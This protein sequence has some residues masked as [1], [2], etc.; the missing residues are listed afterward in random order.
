MAGPTVND[1]AAIA[2]ELAAT[3]ELYLLRGT[4]AGAD[5]KTTGDRVIP[6]II[7]QN[8]TVA[9]NLATY[10]GD[11]VIFST[12]AAAIT[13][14]LNNELPNGRRLII[15]NKATDEVITLAGNGSGTVL[16]SDQRKFVS[17][18]TDIFEETKRLKIFEAIANYPITDTDGYDIIEMTAGAADKTVTLPTLADN[19]G[20][21]III[22]KVDV[23]VGEV[24][25]DG[26]GA[27]T[28]DGLSAIQLKKQYYSVKLYASAAEWNIISSNNELFKARRNI[29]NVVADYPIT[30]IDGV[31]VISVTAAAVDRTITLPTLADNQER[32][33][34]IY[35]KDFSLGDVIIDGEG[36]ET[37]NG[38]ATIKLPRQFS[39]V[40][41]IADTTEWKILSI[42]HPVSDTGW[43]SR[44]DWTNVHIGSVHVTYDNLAVSTFQ[45]GETITCSNGATGVVIADNGAT[46][47]I[48]EQV[49]G[50]GVFPD[51]STLLGSISGATADVNVSSKNVDTNMNHLFD[52]YLSD[53]IIEVFFSSDGSEGNAISLGI[54]DNEG[55]GAVTGRT[56]IYVDNNNIKIQTATNGFTVITDAGTVAQIDGDDSF[57]KVVARKRNI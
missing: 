53:L 13:L 35:K 55:A 49:T 8:T 45:V 29:K 27:E 32:I 52:V 26:E 40:K 7:T 47:A 24:I 23:G 16:P 1:L 34:E 22:N 46:E 25:V 36:A 5:K 38:T 50:A 30:D 3:D 10:F 42:Y 48:L 33:I 15:V 57:Y 20:R 17:D 6:T 21:T 28:I 31:E 12:P 11:L 2:D 56:H 14:T 43:V 9:I 39:K 54:T 19:L 4:G 44:S 41:I 51:P 37:I 18:G